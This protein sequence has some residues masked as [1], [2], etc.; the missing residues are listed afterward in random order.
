MRLKFVPIL[1]VA[2]LC[3]GFNQGCKPAQTGTYRWGGYET[4]LHALA[5]DPAY[6]NQYGANLLKL[7]QDGEGSGKVPPGLY[8]EYGYFL[9]VSQKAP[10]AVLYFQKEKER[11]PESGFFMDRMI[12]LAAA[13]A[14]QEPKP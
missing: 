8:A 2:L 3:L 4:S 7:L 13:P 6:F 10:E 5:K 12:K 14:R 11:W 9:L 1:G